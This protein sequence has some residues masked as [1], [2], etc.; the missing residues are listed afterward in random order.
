MFA[1]QSL[2]DAYSFLDASIND[3]LRNNPPSEDIEQ[4]KYPLGL[5]FLRGDRAGYGKEI[6]KQVVASYNFWSGESGIYFDMVFPGWGVDGDVAA[7][8]PDDF[9]RCKNEFENISKWKY[10]GE[11]D[12]LLLN[13]DFD[14]ERH[15][16]FLHGKGRF[17]FDETIVLPMETMLAEGKVSSL[18]KFMQQLINSCK[19]NSYRSDSS[20]LLQVRD[21]VAIPKGKDVIFKAIREQFLKGFSKVYDELRP[22]AVCNLSQ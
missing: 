10:S 21:K 9:I 14:L 7:Y 5:F 11:T 4:I 20:V 17:N 1:V 12:I 16:S 13:Y 8:F 19:E 22:Y 15:G 3:R 6:M 2:N 18:D